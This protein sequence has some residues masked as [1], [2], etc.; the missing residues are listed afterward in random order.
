VRQ[1]GGALN[2]IDR[3][4]VPGSGGIP[5]GEKKW[6]SIDFMQQQVVSA[7]PGGENSRV[8]RNRT[9]GATGKWVP[10]KGTNRFKGEKKKRRGWTTKKNFTGAGPAD[11]GFAMERGLSASSARWEPCGGNKS[12]RWVRENTP[13]GE[14]GSGPREKVEWK[15]GARGEAR[16][17]AGME[18]R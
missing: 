6:K 12:T 10:Q 4:F 17:V 3:H 2:Q 16:T 15:W 9:E 14:I 13:W 18:T 8:G 1:G 7:R 5:K 11:Q